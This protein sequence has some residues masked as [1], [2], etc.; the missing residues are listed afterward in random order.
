MITNCSGFFFLH[1]IATKCLSMDI[2]LYILITK[3]IMV[4]SVVKFPIV[5]DPKTGLQSSK[6]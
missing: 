2:Y 1:S 5:R 3:K 4:K 6:K